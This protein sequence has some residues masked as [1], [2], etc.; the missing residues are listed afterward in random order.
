VVIA[1][2]CRETAL[3]GQQ[4]LTIRTRNHSGNNSAALLDVSPKNKYQANNNF[5]LSKR[6]HS[7]SN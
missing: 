2:S 1:I 7:K 6:Y 3:F 4:A 5:F